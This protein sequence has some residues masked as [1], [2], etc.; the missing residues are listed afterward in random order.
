MAT[1]RVHHLGSSWEPTLREGQLRQRCALLSASSCLALGERKET[2]PPPRDKKTKQNVKTK[3]DKKKST[4]SSS[5]NQ[6]Q[7][8]GA[9][10]IKLANLEA[11]SF[12]EIKDLGRCRGL[13]ERWLSVAPAGMPDLSRGF[14]HAGSRREITS[15]LQNPE[16]IKKKGSFEAS[17]FGSE[18]LTCAARSPLPCRGTT[19]GIWA[20][21]LGSV[22]PRCGGTH[23]EAL[24]YSEPQRHGLQLI[25]N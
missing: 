6:G 1:H 7:V 17:C 5:E 16:V 18:T 20:R 19:G 3:K 2:L 15:P 22:S 12:R 10:A 25:R 24:K 8:L 21:G 9:L 14:D 11:G 4:L 23:G 13:G